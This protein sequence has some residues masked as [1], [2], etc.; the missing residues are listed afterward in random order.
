MILLIRALTM[1][2]SSTNT[3]RPT[4]AAQISC[5]VVMMHQSA[6][7]LDKFAAKSEGNAAM[8][9]RCRAC[10]SIRENTNNT[11]ELKSVLALKDVLV[12]TTL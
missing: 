6:V 10:G 5:F 4:P 12:T 9:C 7:T 8:K 3:E 11:T 1:P 2:T